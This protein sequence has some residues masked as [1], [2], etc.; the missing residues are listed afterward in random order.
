MKIASVSSV[1]LGTFPFLFGTLGRV[2]IAIVIAPFSLVNRSSF[3]LISVSFKAFLI[4]F[5][6]SLFTSSFLRELKSG[7][8]P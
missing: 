4:V 6:N 2:S 1:V 3:V 5:S 8:L 7:Y